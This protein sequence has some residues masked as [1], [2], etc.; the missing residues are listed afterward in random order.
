MKEKRKKVI[1]STKKK[2]K[3]KRIPQHILEAFFQVIQCEMEGTGNP[4][5]ETYNTHLK[6]AIRAQQTIG[7]DMMMRGFL[8]HERMEAL[9]RQGVPSP[10]QKM[11]AL[12][13]IIWVEILGPLW[14]E[15]N[16]IKH[17]NGGENDEREA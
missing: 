3:K 4:V 16:D 10:E 1:A 8:A 9:I 12:Q 14:F 15:G 13:E 11:N 5:K 6:T 2:G 17:G 7:F